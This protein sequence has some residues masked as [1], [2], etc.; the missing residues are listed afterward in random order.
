MLRFSTRV[1]RM[2]TLAGTALATSTVT[3]LLYERVVHGRSLR[4]GFDSEG[5]WG[6]KGDDAG[7]EAQLKASALC[8]S[9]VRASAP[10]G[11]VCVLVCVC[12]AVA[13]SKSRR[14]W[15]RSRTTGGCTTAAQQLSYA[16]SAA[17]RPSKR[18]DA[19]VLALES[20][21]L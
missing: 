15:R 21:S 4:L 6:V 2:L 17:M 19:A 12:V 8:V 7:L 5:V 20:E 9:C 16:S 1:S 14:S 11:D 13:C 18:S 10:C 3:Y